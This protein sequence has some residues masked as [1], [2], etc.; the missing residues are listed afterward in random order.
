MTDNVKWARKLHLVEV[1]FDDAELSFTRL[2]SQLPGILHARGH[3]LD[4]HD[5]VPQVG[6]RGRILPAAGPQFQ[7]ASDPASGQALDEGGILPV[8]LSD[9]AS[10]T[11]AHSCCFE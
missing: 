7:K 2:R 5:R 3:D 10:Q 8:G 1:A 4:G 6:R 11:P 9:A